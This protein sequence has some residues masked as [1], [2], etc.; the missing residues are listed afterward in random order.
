MSLTVWRLPVELLKNIFQYCEKFY[1][2]LVCRTWYKEALPY[3]YD[4]VDVDG[5][6]SLVQCLQML[7]S[8]DCLPHYI[9]SFCLS[10]RGPLSETNRDQL[11][12]SL[13]K[14]IHL[15]RLELRIL[16]PN[17]RINCFRQ[18]SFPNLV[19]FTSH[20]ELDQSIIDFITSQQ[21]LLEVYLYGSW[22]D[23]AALPVISA[24][25]KLSTLLVCD[26]SVAI[27]IIRVIPILNVFIRGTPIS[28]IKLLDL[29]GS[30]TIHEVRNLEIFPESCSLLTLMSDRF[31][32]LRRLEL[33]ALDT[34]VIPVVFCSVS[35]DLI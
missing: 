6:H 9:R 13:S 18:L 17:M 22:V 7:A 30:D 15:Y 35:I 28:R 11:S 12:E 8:R 2:V 25:P 26:I 32:G 14:M 16:P 23:S 29:S 5:E 4:V 33:R 27:A 24:L 1:N 21:R 19:Y 34:N 20:L 3:F 31:S 10:Q